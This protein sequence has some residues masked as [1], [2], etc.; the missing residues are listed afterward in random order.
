MSSTFIIIAL[1]KLFKKRFSLLVQHKLD[2]IKM[3]SPTVWN[4]EEQS[5]GAPVTLK[6]NFELT[7]TTRLEVNLRPKMYG[8]EWS[9]VEG[10]A[11]NRLL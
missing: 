9:K 11:G 3:I 7:V 6:G 2:S 10:R 1:Q 5:W 8:K 4:T